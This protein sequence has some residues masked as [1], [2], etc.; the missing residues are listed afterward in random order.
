MKYEVTLKCFR[1]AFP[2]DKKHTLEKFIIHD[3]S[4]RRWEGHKTRSEEVAS[5]EPI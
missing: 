5:I 2:N 3:W 4:L 1:N